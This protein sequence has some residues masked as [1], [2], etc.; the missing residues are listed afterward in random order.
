MNESQYNVN[1]IVVTYKDRANY[2]QKIANWVFSENNITS[3][4]IIDNNSVAS[5]REKLASLSQNNNKIKILSFN[6]NLGPGRGIIEAIKQFKERGS[7]FFWILDDDNLPDSNALTNLIL[8]WGNNNFQKNDTM[9]VS[10]R[11]NREN[12][13]KAFHE[14][15]EDILIGKKN[16]FRTFHFSILFPTKK[17]KTSKLDSLPV[18]PY[19]GMFFHKDLLLNIGYPDED[20]CIYFDDHEFSRRLVE[21]GGKI[22]LVENSHII[23]MEQSW[24]HG[25]SKGFM[26]IVK[27]E[28]PI[29]MYYSVRN[30]I[31]FEKKYMINNTFHYLINACVYVSIVLF[32][33]LVNFK[34]NNMKYYIRAL[35]DGFSGN[36]YVRY[37][38]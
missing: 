23:D 1:L 26:K 38:L 29:L 19:G 20:Y 8:F 17:I 3:M 5:S 28:N 24:Y 34:W 37:K 27:T 30:R 2:V 11:K 21:K 10:Y 6:D 14:G 33:M 12:Y 36:K 16:M 22:F 4:I 25:N 35:Y 18:A 7:S 9:L 15:R 32:F 31:F 13:I